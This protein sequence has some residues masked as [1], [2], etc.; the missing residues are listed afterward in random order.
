MMK[1]NRDWTIYQ[2]YSLGSTNCGFGDGKFDTRNRRF[3]P[4]LFTFFKMFI[5][6]YLYF[7]IYS[8]FY[9]LR[10]YFEASTKLLFLTLYGDRWY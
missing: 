9:R 3:L 1:V 4:L 5:N 6:F 7:F 2:S 8:I 10:Y